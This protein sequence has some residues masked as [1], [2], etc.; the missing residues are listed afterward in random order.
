[1][2]TSKFRHIF[3]LAALCG[4]LPA[5]HAQNLEE[6]LTVEGKYTPEVIAADRLSA[7]PSQIPLSAP[8]A[9]LSFDRKGTMANFAPDALRM[10]ATGWQTTGKFNTSRGYVDLRL[11]SWLNSSLSAGYAAINE[12][13]TKLNIRLQHNSTSLWQAWKAD[14]DKGYPYAA[15]K[16]FR[17]DETLGAD[18]THR[19]AG[20]GTLSADLQY[21]LGY[22]NYY[23]VRKG[24]LTMDDNGETKLSAPT[25]TLNDIYAHVGWTG[26]T[27]TPFSYGV[28][29]DVR[30]FGYRAAYVPTP[31]TAIGYEF[32]KSSGM[33]E[34]EINV[35]GNLGYSFSGT[36]RIT[37]GLTYSGLMRSD[38]DNLNRV[39]LTPGYEYTS[40]NMTL[41]AGAELAIVSSGETRFRVAPD[42]RFTARSEN[43]AFSA[44]IGGGT[45][46]RTMAWRHQMDYY[47]SPQ[48][49][50]N[51]AYTPLEAMLAL[52]FNPGGKW[53]IGI[54]GLWRTT[55]DETFG[56]RYMEY[57]NVS[58]PYSSSFW[59]SGTL[60]F[61]G[62]GTTHRI[63]GFSIGV[64]AGY[65]FC[66]YFGVRGKA[67]W[68]P[69][70]GN[71]GILNGFDR[72]AI[73]G[74]LT[75]ESHPTEALDIYLDYNLRA[76]RLTGLGRI[77]RLNLGADYRI[78]EKM[79]VGIE[80][81]NL[82]N[83]HEYAM[84]YQPIEGFTAM[85]RVQILF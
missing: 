7:S 84:P 80:L 46:L 45:H 72:A 36:S 41:H 69:Q 25:Q 2:K 8:V 10:G 1:M 22:F 16:R 66:R 35:G 77:S 15:D 9:N 74:T 60:G 52:Q 3:A 64:N 38:V 48:G 57:L 76:K 4:T 14:Y 33:R 55:L 70:H 44:K 27:G 82:L 6:S 11:G 78:N 62:D 12:P 61:F 20:A 31:L 21:H 39:R 30:Y 32:H 18:F 23:G 59:W 68:Q 63:H 71:S 28:D 19:F 5:L 40:G 53:A 29:A 75:A 73:T 43:V 58:D 54:E 56:G 49:Y 34:T 26:S 79:S 50:S 42:V 24:Y 83:R 51:V 81:D 65:E 47:D 67:N 37:V 85:G 13:D 17:Y